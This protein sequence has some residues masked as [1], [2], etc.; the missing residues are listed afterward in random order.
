MLSLLAHILSSLW[1][2]APVG[3]HTDSDGVINAD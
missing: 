1:G 2:V 3:P